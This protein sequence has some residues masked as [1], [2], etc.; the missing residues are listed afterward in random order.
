MRHSGV[1]GR[2]ADRV[3]LLQRRG[4]V[5]WSQWAVSG[6]YSPGVV[7]SV[8]GVCAGGKGRWLRQKFQGPVVEPEKVQLV[9]WGT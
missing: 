9:R 4:G 7:R 1:Q 8:R 6:V 3:I 5:F 2:G